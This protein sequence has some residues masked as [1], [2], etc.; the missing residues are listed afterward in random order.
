MQRELRAE[1]AWH[2]WTGRILPVLAVALLALGPAHARDKDKKKKQREAEAPAQV[3]PAAQVK[4]PKVILP[5]GARPS[6]ALKMR[7]APRPA[8]RISIDR[9]I[10]Q[11]Q[12]RYKAKVIDTK[13]SQLGAQFIYVLKVLSEDGHVRTVRIDAASGKEL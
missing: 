4:R 13:E 6:P 5:E 1:H 10:Q 3:E 7:E 8:Q 11:V 2:Q 12:R 9:V